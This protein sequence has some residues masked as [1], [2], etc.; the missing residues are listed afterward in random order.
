MV[1]GFFGDH[2]GF[3]DHQ[4]TE[5]VAAERQLEVINA[6]VPDSLGRGP[7]TG[8]TVTVGETTDNS[9]HGCRPGLRRSGRYVDGDLS[10]WITNSYSVCC[11]WLGR[12]FFER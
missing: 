8:V 1:V 9:L 5:I 12:E 11:A 6:C 2:D 7:H 10:T 4:T 3:G